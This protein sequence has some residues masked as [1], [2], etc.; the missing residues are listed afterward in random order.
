MHDRAVALLNLC[1]TLPTHPPPVVAGVVAG[2]ALRCRLRLLVGLL[3]VAPLAA[4]SGEAGEA[5]AQLEL[6]R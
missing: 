6:S 3:P 4:V 1:S 2:L 5:V